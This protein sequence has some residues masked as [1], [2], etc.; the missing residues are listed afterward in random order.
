[1]NLQTSKMELVKRILD[2]NNKALVDTIFKLFR[3]NK[4]DKQEFTEVQIEEIQLGLKQLANGERI[5]IEDYLK[6][7]S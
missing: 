6:K 5:S 3:E 7:V 4:A 1:M 2:T